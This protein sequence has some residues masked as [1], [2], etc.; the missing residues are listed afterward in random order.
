M[1]YPD[2]YSRYLDLRDESWTT[3]DQFDSTYWSGATDIS[4]YFGPYYMADVVQLQFQVHEQVVPYYGYASYTADRMYRGTRLVVGSF[5]M[6]FKDSRYMLALLHALQSN[7]KLGDIH[8]AAGKTLGGST[9]TTA[10]DL[11]LGASLESQQN[12]LYDVASALGGNSPGETATS[13][14]DE[15]CTIQTRLEDL[16]QAIMG[17]SGSDQDSATSPGTESARLQLLALQELRKKWGIPNTP[18][19]TYDRSPSTVEPWFDAGVN[20][21]DLTISYGQPIDNTLIIRRG[22]T[23]PSQGT[24]GD[25]S[26]SEH[27]SPVRGIDW[28]RINTIEKLTGCQI[29]GMQKTLDDSGRSVMEQIDFIAKDYIAGLQ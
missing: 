25:V 13:E 26:W 20:G 18:D 10:N 11:D 29:T 12:L 24:K 4:V 21:F 23:G 22:T 19:K 15:G 8:S 6:N 17:I 28:K 2:Q 14:A 7:P 9:N 16:G 3:V 27:P 5:L 1:P